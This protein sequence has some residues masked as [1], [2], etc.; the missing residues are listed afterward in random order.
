MLTRSKAKLRIG[1]FSPTKMCENGSKGDS[2]SF[3]G[4][5]MVFFSPAT[6][7]NDNHKTTSVARQNT[8][9]GVKPQVPSDPVLEVIRTA[10]QSFGPI[11]PSDA[12][13]L[14]RMLRRLLEIEKHEGIV[15][16]IDHAKEL[17]ELLQLKKC[18]RLNIKR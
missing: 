2:I 18:A 16:A 17:A 1:G 6:P 9:D 5:N 14:S 11:C 8:F 10:I 13:V 3:F 15:V 7:L 4:T 12:M